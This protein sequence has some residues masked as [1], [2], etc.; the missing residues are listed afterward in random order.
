MIGALVIAGYVNISV[1]GLANGPGSDPPGGLIPHSLFLQKEFVT[2][3]GAAMSTEIIKAAHTITGRAF[4]C[5]RLGNIR[6]LSNSQLGTQ[7]LRFLGFITFLKSIQES[8]ACPWNQWP[9]R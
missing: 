6:M 7:Q 3:E 4:N 5:E 2:I 9:G 1:L 8:Y